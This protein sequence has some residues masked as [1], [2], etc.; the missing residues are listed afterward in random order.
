MANALHIDFVPV[1]PAP[2]TRHLMGTVRVDCVRSMLVG[3][4]AS[5][6]SNI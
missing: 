6:I 3:N 2:R 1:R 4:A 5:S